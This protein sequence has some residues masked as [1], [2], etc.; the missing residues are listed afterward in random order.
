MNYSEENIFT[1]AQEK[2]G[3]EEVAEQLGIRLHKVGGSL[4]AN[5]IFGDG[6]GENA[7]AVYP[8]SGRWY[9]FMNKQGGDVTDLV[10]V[11]K[12]NGDKYKALQ[13][14]MPEFT[15]EKVKFQ[16]T[17]RD[18]F[19][20]DIERWHNDLM[21]PNKP[22]SVRALAYLHSRRITEATIKRL[23]I[24][25]MASGSKQR[26]I[27]PYWDESGKKVLYFT[28]R[29]YDWSGHGEDENEPKYMKASLT[30]YPLLK[31]SILGL[32][33][34][35]RDKDFI[36]VTE[37]MFD[38]LAFEQEGYS[39]IS[40][41]GG[42]FG[43]L[44]PQAVEIMKDFKMVYLAFDND[45]AGREFAYKMSRELIKEH[46]PFNVVEHNIGKDIA[47]YYQVQG[48][49]DELIECC[50]MG[51][52]WVVEECL[53]P[54]KPL[55]QMTISQRDT[56]K[57]HIRDFILEI[58]PFTDDA[59][60]TDIVN[61]LDKNFDK[62]W[63]T[64]LRRKGQKGMSEMEIIDVVKAQHKLMYNDK[65]GFYE[66]ED[67]I[68]KAKANDQ[69]GGHIMDVYGMK[70][71]GSKVDNTL[72]L[73]KKDKSIWSEIP[74]N[75]FNMLPRVTFPNGTVH[76]DLETGT[77]TLKQHNADDYTTVKL[78]YRYDEKATC[79][80]I[81]KFLDDV[82][83]GN[84]KDRM[85]LEEFLGYLLL[86]NCKF[87]KALMLIGEGSNG[88]SVFVNL[89][90][91][92]LGGTNGYVSTVEPSK[93]SKDFRLMP[94]K[95]SWLNIS[96]DS[97]SDLRGSEGEFK[98]IV[99]GEDLEDSYKFH[100][101]FSFPTRSKMMMCCNKFPTV[102]DTSEGFIRRFLILK[103][104]RHY[105]SPNRI[106]NE[107][108]RPIDIDLEVKLEKELPG[109]FNLALKG[110]QR[111]LAQGQFTV[112]D[113]QEELIN[114]FIGHNVNSMSLVEEH[115]E[116]FFDVKDTVKEGKTVDKRKVYRDYK[117]WSEETN[118]FPM[119]RKKF[120]AAITMAFARL[121]WKFTEK[122]NFWTFEDIKIKD[123][124]EQT[125]D[126]V[127]GN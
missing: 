127:A 9:D 95:R 82:T 98:K 88:K 2:Y 112:T 110:L 122:D 11:V 56:V 27:F 79:P 78:P 86:P 109:L 18:K 26:F 69:V 85:L 125:K 106:T 32:N 23:K 89:A 92:M 80:N 5:S 116:L 103:F 53:A 10:A 74:L 34:L 40:P 57:K 94:F 93:L 76:I 50:R 60:I 87:Q 30:A 104:K 77:A 73:L 13:E 17:Q 124:D 7:F 101:P 68:W 121:G 35:D 15:S 66:Y 41:N 46:I 54:K 118:E 90:K 108:D 1:A 24:G 42:D 120:Y 61:S 113:E 67:G 25:V 83:C 91:K 117:R 100:S 12:F 28:T 8:K 16:K 58:S 37:G 29:R 126:L 47:D 65:C 107:N 48:T 71:T 49:L 38:W 123:A 114:K 81:E 22:M 102:I 43:K 64:D 70:A 4:R 31:N 72:R 45:D 105:V 115:E 96:T 84:K 36:V 111:L 97:D 59:D 19:M 6:E 119:S 62:T 39:V 20:Q 33:T 52:K 63:L 99:A 75:S 14:L 55:E 44:T 3:I 51:T 21:N